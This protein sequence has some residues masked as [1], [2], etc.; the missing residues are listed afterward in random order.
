MD[1]LRSELV[2]LLDGKGAHAGFDRAVKDFDPKLRGVRVSCGHQTAPHSAWELLE[3]I[4][5]AQYD[6]LEFS[7]NP[8]YESPKW[9]EG[10]WPATPEPPDAKAWDHSVAEYKKDL[11]AMK[12][13]IA[14]PKSDLNTP[15]PHGEGQTLLREALQLADHTAY[16]VGEIVFLRRLL[17]DW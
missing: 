10:Y 1:H 8:K 3:H 5:I 11:A 17:N 14:D 13:L 9:P 12:A 15:F 6:M 16:H 4:R 7:R 2:R